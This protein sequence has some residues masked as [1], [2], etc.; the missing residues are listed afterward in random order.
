MQDLGAHILV[1]VED[2][3]ACNPLSDAADVIALESGIS[4]LARLPLV[5]PPL[6]HLAYHRAIAKHFDPDHP[7]N[8][9][10]VVSL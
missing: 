2:A 4:E 9:T 1:L 6:Q 5:L 8:L 3:H 7:H 10:A